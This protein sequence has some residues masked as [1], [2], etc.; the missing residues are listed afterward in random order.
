MEGIKTATAAAAAASAHLVEQQFAPN[1]VHE[2]AAKPTEYGADDTLGAHLRG[3]SYERLVD[4]SCCDRRP[5]A[6]G[7]RGGAPLQVL[8]AYYTKPDEAR[9]AHTQS[10]A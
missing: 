8:R 9:N 1:G 6:Y 5:F 7:G 2:E 10:E 4:N 3:F